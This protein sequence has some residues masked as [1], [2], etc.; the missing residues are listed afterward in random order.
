[1]SALEQVLAIFMARYGL[2]EPDDSEGCRAIQAAINSKTPDIAGLRTLLTETYN[3]Y[4]HY[5]VRVLDL[6]AESAPPD[7]QA[8]DVDEASSAADGA[9]ALTES[10]EKAEPPPKKRASVRKGK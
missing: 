1:M 4:P 9:A 5:E 10:T 8:P 2:K 7:E 3:L 6:L